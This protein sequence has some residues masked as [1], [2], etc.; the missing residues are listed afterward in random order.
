M[1][2]VGFQQ[3]DETPGSAQGMNHW[4][5]RGTFYEHECLIIEF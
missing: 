2:R 4:E 1:E 3:H 5:S